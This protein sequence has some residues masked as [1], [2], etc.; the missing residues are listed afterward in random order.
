MSQ[1][2][3]WRWLWNEGNGQWLSRTCHFDRDFILVV[4]SLVRRAEHDVLLE[5]PKTGSGRRAGDS[6]AG[7]VDVLRQHR[8][9]QEELREAMGDA[10]DDQGRVFADAVGG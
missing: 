5:P 2:V 8:A 1:Q 4:C 3:P 6:D 10:Y 9:R 7:T